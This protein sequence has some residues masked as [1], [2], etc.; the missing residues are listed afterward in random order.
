MVSSIH[1]DGVSAQIYS[2]LGRETTHVDEGILSEQFT[3]AQMAKVYRTVYRITRNREDAEDAM[4]DACLRAIS[5]LE[6]FDGRSQFSTWL[7]RIA[8]NASLMILR[9]RK[10]ARAVPLENVSDSESS[11]SQE[12]KDTAPNPEKRYLQKERETVLQEAIN[13]LPPS[14]KSAIEIVKLRETSLNE[15]AEL[16]GLSI[17]AVKGRLF[18]A[19][20]VLRRSKRLRPFRTSLPRNSRQPRSTSIL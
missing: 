7:T 11:E 17:A 13:A 18:H 19:R 8:M 10:I 20:R 9:K 1:R 5:H 6:S 15:S 14:L 12:V 16:M 2:G 3:K 4:Q